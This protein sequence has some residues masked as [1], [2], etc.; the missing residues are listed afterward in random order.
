MKNGA[1][2]ILLLAVIAPG[3]KKAPPSKLTL[4]VGEVQTLT[5]AEAGIGVAIHQGIQLAVKEINRSGGIKGQQVE[6]ITLDDQ[7]RSEEASTAASRLI[8]QDHVLAL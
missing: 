8:S 2:I 7:G 1:L 3:C 6:L 4:K 5:G